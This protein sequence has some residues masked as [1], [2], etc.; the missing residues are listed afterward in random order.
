MDNSKRENIKVIV[1][2]L[3]AVIVLIAVEYY[4]FNFDAHKIVNHIIL[5]T[6]AFNILFIFKF[7]ANPKR[8]NINYPM[9]VCLLLFGVMTYNDYLV[10]GKLDN[11]DLVILVFIFGYIVFDFFK[12]KQARKSLK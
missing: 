1:A 4:F 10:A 5:L 6:L 8:S 9:V 2:Y 11:T 7:I 12:T 3:I